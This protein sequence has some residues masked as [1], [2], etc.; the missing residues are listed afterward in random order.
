MELMFEKLHLEGEVTLG[1]VTH[2]ED[3]QQIEQLQQQLQEQSK[4]MARKAAALIS[5]LVPLDIKPQGDVVSEGGLGN[6]DSEHSEL[7]DILSK[8]MLDELSEDQAL[9][10]INNM[11][12]SLPAL[13]APADGSAETSKAASPSKESTSSDASPGTPALAP[14]A[15]PF[16]ERSASSSSSSSTGIDWATQFVTLPQPDK[17]KRLISRATSG[18]SEGVLGP[19]LMAASSNLASQ[20]SSTRPSQAASLPASLPGLPPKH[21]SV[22]ADGHADVRLGSNDSAHDSSSHASWLTGSSMLGKLLHFGSSG[23]QAEAPIGAHS[24]TPSLT[25]S[26][27]NSSSASHTSTNGSAAAHKPQIALAPAKD[28]NGS[29]VRRTSSTGSNNSG[30]TGAEVVGMMANMLSKAGSG[31]LSKQAQQEGDLA[32]GKSGGVTGALMGRMPGTKDLMMSAGDDVQ[33]IST[34]TDLQLRFK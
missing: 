18:R 8:F 16:K 23:R 6:Q 12:I 32:L 22:D 26:D 27:S 9:E 21:P 28:A 19:M 14:P 11:K 10:R 3:V 30:A 34:S 25:H 1:S 2:R 31:A 29:S 24:S 17:L 5:G 33:G 13:Q 20:T 15:S 7:V 4:Q